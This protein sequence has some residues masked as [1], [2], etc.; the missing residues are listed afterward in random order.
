M[1]PEEHRRIVGEIT[2]A[3]APGW[4]RRRTRIESTVAPVRKWM[5]QMLAPGPGNIVLE[6]GAGVGDTGFEAAAIIG[7]NGRLISTDFSTEMVDAARRRGAALGL[8]NVDYRVMDAERTGLDDQS[9]DGVLCRFAY[10]LMADPSAAL[11]ETRRV[12]RP[13]KRVALSVWGAPEHNPW[14]S[15]LA[16]VLVER[17]HTTP[18]EPGAPDAFSMGNAER[19]RAML[20]RAGFSEVRTQELP[21]TFA[22]RDAADYVSYASDTAGPFAIV[23]RGLSD[24]DRQAVQSRLAEAFAGF[25]SPG[26]YEL[27]GLALAAVAS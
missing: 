18:P 27:P 23:L 2:A 3:L 22:F 15:I 17:G 10:M 4:E 19:T 5:I 21:V 14:I 25:A 6:L 16:R 8:R 12:L 13:G 1:K 20:T 24:G 7:E 11:V 9:V 26:G